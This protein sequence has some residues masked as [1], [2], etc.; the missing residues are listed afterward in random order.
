MPRPV[1][2]MLLV[3]AGGAVGTLARSFVIMVSESA[4]W[5]V[6][7]ALL[8]VNSLG[9]AV[10]GWFTVTPRTVEVRSLVAVGALAS[11]TTFSGV[12]VAFVEGIRAGTG[13]ASSILLVLSIIVGIGSA[14]LGRRLAS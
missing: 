11:F 10:L 5:S 8:I 3:F 4:G 9:A 14:V 7:V 1:L 6:W 2:I 12:T 13:L